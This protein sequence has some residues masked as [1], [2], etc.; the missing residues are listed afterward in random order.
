MW[1]RACTSDLLHITRVAKLQHAVL[2]FRRGQRGLARW[3]V[4]VVQCLTFLDE[5]FYL[6]GKE[7]K[8]MWVVG[9]YDKKR[10][11]IFF[12]EVTTVPLHEHQEC[13][14]YFHKSIEQACTHRHTTTSGFKVDQKE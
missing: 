9:R 2:Y 1:G 7:K 6:R 14:A 4:R 10:I 8:W 5:P 13:D 3:R 12:G 11:L